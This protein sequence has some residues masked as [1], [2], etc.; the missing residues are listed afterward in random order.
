[1]KFEKNKI[2]FGILVF[3]LIVNLLV[4][5]DIQYFYLRAIFSFIFLITIPGLL[6][7]LILKIRKIG[8]WEYLVYIIGLSVAFL[9]FGGLFINW[10]FSLIGIDKPLSLM[11][12]LIS[13]DIFLLIFWIIALKRNNKISL[14][15]EQPR[16]DFINKT[17]LIL[18]VIFPILSILGAT[19]LNNH[20]PNY[21]TKI[22]LGG[23]AVYVFFVVLFRNKLNKNIFPWSI[24]MVSLSLL[25]AA[26]L[27]SWY[28]SGVDA[29]LEYYIFQLIKEKQYWSVQL[30][31]HAYN[32]CISVSI[33]PTILSNFMKINDQYIFKFIFPIIFSFTPF[34]VYLF[35]KKFTKEIPAFI[36]AF[37]FISQPTFINSAYIP[38]R[39]EIALLFFTL[40]L[41]VLFNESFNQRLRNSSFII[42]G[43]TMVV[44]HYTTTYLA[45]LLFVFSYLIYFVFRKTKDKKPFLI[46]Y[47]KLNLIKRGEKSTNKTHSLSGIA[48]VILIIFTFFWNSTLPNSANNLIDFTYQT[49]KNMNKIFTESLSETGS[50]TKQWNI[51]YYRP[52]DSTLLLQDYIKDATLKYE[53]ISQINLYP[54]ATYKNY[55]PIVKYAKGDR[56][57]A[58]ASK[59]YLFFNV[60]RKLIK[61]FIIVGVLWL[62]FTKY[63]KSTNNAEYITMTLFGVF[64]LG[65]FTILPLTSIFYTTVRIYQQVLVILSLPAVFGGLLIFKFFKKNIR[66]IFILMIFIL[67]YLFY[68]NVMPYNII[69][70]GASL[71]LNNFGGVYDQ[72]YVHEAEIKSSEWLFSNRP[73]SQL[74]Y[75]DD[76]ASYKLWF[77]SKNDAY[78]IIK[79][80][81]PSVIDKEAFVYSSYTNTIEKRGFAY[82]EG[83]EIG[84]NFPSEFLNQNKS[85]IYNNG[86]T[87]IFK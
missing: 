46:I 26:S 18:P 5:F 36:A 48:I 7:M 20:G 17:F 65:I 29:N 32:V 67:Y 50:I 74:I 21:L 58:T 25:L 54:R 68:S 30:F 34:M 27:R 73:K 69:G 63:K 41:L 22:V 49:I 81:F 28:V 45:I 33:L 15:V 71:Q 84:Y 37:F 38:I 42:F 60:I 14:E 66:L 77:S 62:T 31:S 43:F 64:L 82:I 72:L 79:D 85:K 10:V 59:L 12:L 9:M 83:Q 13:F 76:R 44:S 1:M 6:I 78:N 47:K 61:V 2:F 87:E 70:T 55:Q 19:T 3:V 24:I 80:V 86:S 39:Q 40:T 23:I 11:P 75:A 16:L 53:D 57:E 35:L 51:F 56:L 8:F 52:K 4:L